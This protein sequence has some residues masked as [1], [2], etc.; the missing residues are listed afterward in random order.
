MIRKDFINFDL[1]IKRWRDV[2]ISNSMGSPKSMHNHHHNHHPHPHANQ[3]KAVYMPSKCVTDG[4]DE[5][6]N[7]SSSVTTSTQVVSNANPSQQSTSGPSKRDY[8]HGDIVRNIDDDDD[9]D[10]D[11]EEE[12]DEEDDDEDEDE[13][14]DEM[15]DRMPMAHHINEDD[16]DDEDEVDD[17]E[18]EVDDIDEHYAG[19]NDE[20]DDEDEE[21]EIDDGLRRS[22]NAAASSGATS[23][24][25]RRFQRSRR[26][27]NAVKK[28]SVGAAKINKAIKQAEV[29]SN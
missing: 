3:P 29:N 27:V 12:E 15:I 25:R 2:L 4:V 16:C 7:K 19:D 22:S 23:E 6:D 9:E 10:E 18:D 1:N 28:N 17:E 14:E 20:D 11:D 13:C 8:D 21:D 5:M 26:A 24:E